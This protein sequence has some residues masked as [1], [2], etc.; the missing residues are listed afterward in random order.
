MSEHNTTGPAPVPIT[1]RGKIIGY[2]CGQ[3]DRPATVCRGPAGSDA[4]L[5]AKRDFADKC[6]RC[7]QC[8]AVHTGGGWCQACRAVTAPTHEADVARRQAAAIIRHEAN[9]AIVNGPCPDAE[10]RL[11]AM[12]RAWEDSD[13]PSLSLE[14]FAACLAGAEALKRE[15]QTC[16]NC[17]H[18]DTGG[19]GGWLGVMRRAL[20]LRY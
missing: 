9:R 7:R 4:D 10:T 11:R 15:Q 17:R 12:H 20:R 14:D 16:G 13:E 2:M 3:C 18:V 8:G 5:A 6:C 19:H 1:A